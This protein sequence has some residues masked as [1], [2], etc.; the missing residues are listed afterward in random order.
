[1]EHPANHKRDDRHCGRYTLAFGNANPI[2][3]VEIPGKDSD[4]KMAKMAKMQCLLMTGECLWYLRQ[5]R[6]Q[7][8]GPVR[9]GLTL[10]VNMTMAILLFYTN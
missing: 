6:I 3:P 2:S 7:R 4:A 10:V 5:G 9:S 8:T 1:M